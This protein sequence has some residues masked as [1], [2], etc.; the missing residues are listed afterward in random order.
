M[1]DLVLKGLKIAGL[2]AIAGV[3][4]V[5]HKKYNFNDNNVIENI[6]DTEIK[7]ETGISIDLTN[8]PETVLPK[9]WKRRFKKKF[10]LPEFDL[11]PYEYLRK[12][13][14]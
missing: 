7:D 9:V 3:I 14:A 13:G 8:N 4:Y 12:L 2:F 10:K 5:A 6:V 1:N 11:R